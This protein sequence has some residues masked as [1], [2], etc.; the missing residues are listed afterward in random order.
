MHLASMFS[1]PSAFRKLL[2][3]YN[4]PLCVRNKAGESSVDVAGGCEVSSLFIKYT[5]EKSSRIHTECEELQSVAKRMFSGKHA[6][7]QIF[8]VGFPRQEKVS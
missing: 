2:F 5:K 3:E 4:A 6:L 8:V 1:Q 7:T